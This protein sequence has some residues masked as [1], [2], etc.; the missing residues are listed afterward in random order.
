MNTYLKLVSSRIALLALAVALAVPVRPALA[1]HISCG[2]VLTKDTKLDRDLINCP[3]DGL[4]IGAD[5]ITITLNG[6]SISGTGAPGSAGIRNSGHDHVTIADGDF[7][8]LDIGGF[9]IGILQSGVRNNRVH[10]LFIEGSSFGI[11]FFNSDHNRVE[12]NIARGGFINQCGQV[13]AA[14]IALFNSDHNRIRENMAELTD[15]GIALVNSDHNRVEHNQAAPEESDGNACFGIVLRDGSDDN[16]VRANLASQNRGSAGD[17]IFVSAGSGG[18]SAQGNGNPAQ[19]LNV[20]CAG[21]VEPAA[22]D[23]DV[24]Y[25]ER[26]PR[27]SRYAVE[28]TT[29]DGVPFPLPRLCPGTETNK[30]WPDA[31]ESVTYTAHVQNK[32]SAPS[33]AFAFAWLVNGAIVAQGSAAPLSAG[34]EAT[35]PYQT[36]WPTAP[37][38]IEF[39][40]DPDN[41]IVETAETNNALTI[42][43]HDLTISIWVEQGL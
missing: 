24:T 40:V 19:C 21:S 37:R 16:Y 41:A 4:V 29:Q 32:G 7:M 42:G 3:G 28:Y 15:V 12:G 18:N 31:G 39:R 9:E 2:A 22:T 1:S 10:S 25:I 8:G 13:M 36:T 34:A 27:Y 5:H 6:H 30:R 20:N 43:S 11:A 33:P 17:G 23:L 38:A 26:T 14:G 35:I